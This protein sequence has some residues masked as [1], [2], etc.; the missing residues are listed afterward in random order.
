[1]T[2][3]RT[4]KQ[5]RTGTGAANSDGDTLILPGHAGAATNPNDRPPP[6]FPMKIAFD[7]PG[8][9]ASGSVDDALI[10]RQVR[11]KQ[12]NHRFAISRPGEA[13]TEGYSLDGPTRGNSRVDFMS[14]DDKA[15]FVPSRSDRPPIARSPRITR[16]AKSRSKPRASCGQDSEFPWKAWLVGVCV[17][18][19]IALVAIALIHPRGLMIS[20]S[21]LV[22]L[23]S[24]LALAGLAAGAYG[25]FCEDFLYGFFYVV[26][27]IYTAYYLVTRWED[28][29]RWM[30]GSTA[31]LGLIL[32]GATILRWAGIAD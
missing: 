17:I 10:G 5:A 31:G 30:V 27:P 3:T 14:T 13:E 29:W 1:V 2:R 26:F 8:C 6:G 28:L 32:L 16:R 25:A 4:Y 19:A 9:G 21:V 24:V 12:C 15:V 23:G 18:V 20:G 11:C 7:C 22:I